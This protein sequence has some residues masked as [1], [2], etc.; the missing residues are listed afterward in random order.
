MRLNRFA[1]FLSHPFSIDKSKLDE[2]VARRD[3]G[4]TLGGSSKQ[5]LRRS[6]SYKNVAG[7]MSPSIQP[8]ARLSTLEMLPAEL[9][10]DILDWATPHGDGFKDIGATSG[11]M[12]SAAITQALHTL[13]AGLKS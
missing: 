1:A 6:T 7:W 11:A 2:R 5:G 9:L 4:D 12:R 10:G 3:A 13:H 8:K